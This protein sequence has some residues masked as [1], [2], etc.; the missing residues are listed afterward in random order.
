MNREEQY[1][2]GFICP[3][4]QEIMTDPVIAEDGNSYERQA[5][6]DWLKIKKISPITREPMNGRL[7][8]DLELKKKIDIERNK[9]E[10]EQRQET[11][12]LKQPLMLGQLQ[13]IQIQQQE[14]ECQKIIN[15]L[16]GEKDNQEI[17][18]RLQDKQD[19]YEIMNAIN[20]GVADALIQIFS[21]R[22]LNLI[23]Q[24]FPATF[25]LMTVACNEI[26]HI[27]FNKQP[28]SSLLRLLDHEDIKV[29]DFALLSIYHI[30]I[31]TG[32][33][34]EPAL[35]PHY[36]IMV[37]LD[38][39]DKIFRMFNRNDIGKNSK[40]Y[41]AFCISTLFKMQ[42]IPNAIMSEQII[43]HLKSI[44]N[45]PMVN[46]KSL[47]KIGIVLLAMNYSNKV[48]IEKDGFVVPELDD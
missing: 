5:I 2:E 10:K 32:M 27:L 1:N 14:I 43:D 6:V 28:Y 13:G 23:T 41:A 40:D 16:Y 45:D 35:H 4:T 46:N 33:T 11:E 19:N 9:Q 34:E 18:N 31:S 7:L 25:L 17:K 12:I 8:P 42:K 36:R 37:E 21:N 15:R 3:I 39:I 47:A 24:K 20:A 48:E 44:I 26:K 22:P 38:G 30:I 29:A